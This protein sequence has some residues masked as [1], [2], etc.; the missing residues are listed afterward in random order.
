MDKV[1]D[2]I[3]LFAERAQAFKDQL[4]DVYGCTY[5]N[6]A[7]AAILIV[8]SLALS[9]CGKAKSVADGPAKVASNDENEGAP[10]TKSPADAHACAT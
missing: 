1:T 3:S 5:V 6:L 2:Q 8:L 10:I 9:S 7:I 4:C